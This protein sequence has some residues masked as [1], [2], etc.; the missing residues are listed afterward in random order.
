MTINPE[1]WDQALAYLRDAQGLLITAGAGMGVDSGLPEFRGRDGLW[2]AY[3]ALRH[4][5]LNFQRIACPEAF[6]RWPTLA[7]G[8]YGHRLQLYRNTEPHAGFRILWNWSRRLRHGAFVFTS[9]VDGQFQKAG[10]DPDRILEC[11][12]SLHWLQCHARCGDRIWSAEDVV[13]DVNLERCRLRSALPACPSCG[14]LARPNVLMFD[15][16]NWLPDR[17][18]EQRARLEAWLSAVGTDRLAV[19]ELGAGQAIPTVRYF[20]LR[21]GHP[22]IRIN[23]RDPAISPRHGVGLEGSALDVLLRLDR[24]CNPE[25]GLGPAVPKDERC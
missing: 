1:K 19:V 21:T 12:G 9:N 25:A 10:F 11:H 4:T 14:G 2:K 7:W 23:A 3:P 17:M 24:R 22:V 15:D 8:F 18:L 5:R 20:S 13:P 6:D 16:L